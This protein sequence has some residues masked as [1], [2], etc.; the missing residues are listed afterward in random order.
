MA[1]ASTALGIDA[2]TAA[3]CYFTKGKHIAHKKGLRIMAYT[4]YNYSRNKNAI[5]RGIDLL[6]T[7]DPASI[8]KEFNRFNY[9]Y[10]IP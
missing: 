1:R 4:P 8:L 3:S 9:D 10:I 5:K 6:E 7:D 2:E